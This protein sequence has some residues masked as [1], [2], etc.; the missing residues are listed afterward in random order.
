MVRT[1]E[2]DMVVVII[3]VIVDPKQ[4][5]LAL[6]FFLTTRSNRLWRLRFA[7][8]DVF[9]DTNERTKYDVLRRGV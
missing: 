2:E 4:R 8:Y 6:D 5:W 1:K 3:I 7:K 9:S